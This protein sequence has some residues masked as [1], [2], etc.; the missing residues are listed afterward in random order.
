MFLQRSGTLQNAKPKVFISSCNAQVL[1]GPTINLHRTPI[2]GRNFEC[3]GEDPLLTGELAA[4]FV[5]GVQSQGVGAC[6]KHFVCNDTE[7]QR[8]TISSELDERTLREIYLR[9]F[10]IAVKRARP[11]AL[12]SAYNRVNGT[13]A[14]SHARLLRDVLRC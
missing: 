10:E 9:P 7:Y 1:L 11:W 8:H 5:D 14:S 3:Y 2:G 6:V 4:A 13:Y 12:M